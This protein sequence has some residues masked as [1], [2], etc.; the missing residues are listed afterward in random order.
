[1]KY[2]DEIEKVQ[3]KLLFAVKKRANKI[4]FQKGVIK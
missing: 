1:M 4:K 2:K 3:N